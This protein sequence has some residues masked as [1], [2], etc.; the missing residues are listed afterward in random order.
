MGI[1][2]RLEMALIILSKIMLV[3]ILVAKMNERSISEFAARTSSIELAISIANVIMEQ[4][5]HF[6]FC[7]D[8]LLGRRFVIEEKTEEQLIQIHLKHAALIGESTFR[9]LFFGEGVGAGTSKACWLFERLSASK[10][11]VD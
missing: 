2:C 4:H 7:L 9:L 10:S 6:E 5:R 11:V 1:G 3:G 8:M